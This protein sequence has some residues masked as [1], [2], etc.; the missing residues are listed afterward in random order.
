MHGMIG[1]PLR[2]KTA[3]VE[4]E[5]VVPTHTIHL[6]SAGHVREELI[7]PGVPPDLSRH[8]TAEP[9]PPTAEE[10]IVYRKVK[11]WLESA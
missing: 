7:Y 5:V 2:C 6:S 8:P 1:Y 11:H 9:T 3:E 4:P 10:F